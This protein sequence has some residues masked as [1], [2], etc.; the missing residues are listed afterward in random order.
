MKIILWLGVTN[1]MCIK[2]LP[3]HSEL[4]H[5]SI[6]MLENHSSRSHEVDKNL[7]CDSEWWGLTLKQELAHSKLGHSSV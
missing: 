4:K 5:Y 2:A 1:H 3:N 7:Y 6:R